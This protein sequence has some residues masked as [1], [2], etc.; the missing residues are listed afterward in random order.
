MTARQW[1]VMGLLALIWGS[2]FL[3]IKWG[4][5]EMSP[6][7]VV[8]GRMAMGLVFLFGALLARG[9]HLPRRALWKPLFVVAIFNNVLPWLCLSWGEQYISSGLASILNATTPLFSIMLASTWGDER[10]SK[11][12]LG[13][14]AV[15]FAGV[16]VLIGADLR[17]FF[18]EDNRVA[19][20]ELAVIIASI[21]YAI[22][23]VFARR[24]MRGE[25]ALQL[26]TGQL[27]ISSL[28]VLPF[29]LLPSNW[30]DTLPS[31]KALLGVA[32]LGFFGSG[33]A[34]ILF[35][36]LL[37]QVGATGTVVVTYLLPV[38]AVFLGWAVEG[39]S[40][41]LRT[42]TGM[43]LILAGILLVNQIGMGR[44]RAARAL[45]VSDS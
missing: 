34:Y 35:Y 9:Q 28:I 5:T 23:A 29:A 16:V 13:G 1:S 41:L 8:A 19:L 44:L 18:A 21:S 10:F 39:E 36:S 25:S 7:M 40:I 32:A 26:A 42:I 3:F 37:E 15:G 2:S 33:L 11:I 43:A 27:L 31:T 24:T 22:G 6:L 38:V 17:D 12:R 45:R 14:L 30:P 20:G 4:V